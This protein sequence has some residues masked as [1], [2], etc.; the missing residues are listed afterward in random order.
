MQAMWRAVIKQTFALIHGGWSCTWWW[1][2]GGGLE[3]CHR[4]E[5]PLLVFWTNYPDVFDVVIFRAL[6]QTARTRPEH[7]ERAEAAAENCQKSFNPSPEH[8]NVIAF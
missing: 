4:R 3:T 1:W 6:G 5:Q 7:A 2:W 8:A